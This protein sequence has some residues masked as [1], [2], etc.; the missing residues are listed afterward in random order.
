MHK[1]SGYKTILY[2]FAFYKINQ[3]GTY[4][5]GVFFLEYSLLNKQYYY[6]YFFFQNY[7]KI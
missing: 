2:L 1:T 3:V 7:N 5:H 4:Q 6:Y